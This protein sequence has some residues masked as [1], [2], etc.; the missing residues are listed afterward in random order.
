MMV[1]IRAKKQGKLESKTQMAPTLS[2]WGQLQ[3]CLDDNRKQALRTLK[4]PSI[5]LS[6]IFCYDFIFTSQAATLFPFSS[7]TA[8]TI[9][10]QHSICSTYPDSVYYFLSRFKPQSTVHSL[11]LLFPYLYYQP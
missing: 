8:V 7:S 3:L 11:A 5:P 1:P 2:V 9:T 4:P 10:P 6:N